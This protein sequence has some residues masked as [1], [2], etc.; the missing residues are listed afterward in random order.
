MEERNGTNNKPF[1]TTSQQIY[2]PIFTM[3]DTFNNK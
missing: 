1:A 3:W 2:K